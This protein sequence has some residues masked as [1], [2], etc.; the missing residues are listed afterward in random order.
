[1]TRHIHLTLIA[2][3]TSLIVTTAALAQGTATGPS[4]VHLADNS[5]VAYA[6]RVND[7]INGPGAYPIDLDPAGLPWRKAIVSDLLTGFVGFGGFT[8]IETVQNV[9]TEPWFDWHEDVFS[10][11]LGV[12]W[13]GVMSVNVNG[14]PIT[15]NETIT[16]N[17]LWI[18]TFSLP[19][20][21]G[22]VLT[23]E[24]DLVTTSNVV[25]PNVTLLEILEFPTPEPAS[26]A[27]M[28]L[29]SLILM[30][31]RKAPTG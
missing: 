4:T 2:L 12:A 19:V 17:S 28:G 14:S 10:G 22:D 7:T 27:L 21:P 8:M 11:A 1:M 9:G 15:F 23:I 30:A 26:A 3:C 25:A 6:G 13:G 24:K 20:L 31:R 5:G 29:G 18:D 16:G